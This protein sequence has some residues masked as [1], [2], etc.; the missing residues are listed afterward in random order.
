MVEVKNI[1]KKYADNYAVKDLSFSVEKGCVY[2]FLGANGAGKTTTLN[3]ITGCLGPDSG[4]VK[5]CGKDIFE[6]ALEAKKH[7][8]YLPEQPPLYPDMTVLEYLSFVAKAK[9]IKKDAFDPQLRSV[10]EKTSLKQVLHRLIKN[11]SKGFKQR[12]GLAAA[13]LGEPDVLILDEPTVGLDPAQLIEIRELLKDYGKNHTVII[14][15]HILSEIALICDRVLIIS[16]GRFVVEDTPAALSEKAS[17]KSIIKLCAKCPSDL[18]LQ[19]LKAVDGIN[20]SLVRNEE[21]SAELE[22][23]YSRRKDP[24]EE[25]FFLF[26]DKRIAL[27]HFEQKQRSLEQVFLELTDQQKEK[28]H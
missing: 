6:N 18:A 27:T 28:K 24:R 15:S 2:G 12:V 4:E 16:K 25:I 3:I 10:I 26:A 17:G 13:L 11:L 14:S 20:A 21:D 19:L 1:N 5:I 7:V 22:I 23:S 8:G 9:A